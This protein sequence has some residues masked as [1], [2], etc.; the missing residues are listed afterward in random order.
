MHIAGPA[1]GP[2]GEESA[3]EH[4]PEQVQAFAGKFVDARDHVAVRR[5]ISDHGNGPR[6]PPSHFF[7]HKQLQFLC[8]PGQTKEQ[9]TVRLV[10]G[11][12]LLVEKFNRVRLKLAPKILAVDNE[13]LS[14]CMK[15]SERINKFVIFSKIFCLQHYAN[16][17]RK[18]IIMIFS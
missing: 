1:S 18:T 16:K 11:C 10:V 3:R 17:F 8:F 14:K 4:C 5:V 2:H 9:T 13:K 12:Q 7:T 6:D 15:I